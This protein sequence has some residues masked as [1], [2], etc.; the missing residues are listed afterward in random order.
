MDRSGLSEGDRFIPYW[1]G[2]G[3]IELSPKDENVMGSAYVSPKSVLVVVFNN[4]DVDRDITVRIDTAE[5]L[6]RK[7]AVRVSDAETQKEVASS[8]QFNV[9]MPKRDFRLLVVRPR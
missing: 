2:A 9:L 1:E 7:D 4:T 8:D 6:G 3:G 5:L